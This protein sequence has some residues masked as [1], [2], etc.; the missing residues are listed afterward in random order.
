MTGFQGN[1]NIQLGIALEMEKAA[2]GAG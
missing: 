2:R 1:I